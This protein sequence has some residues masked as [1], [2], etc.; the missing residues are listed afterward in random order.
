MSY[1]QQVSSDSSVLRIDRHEGVATLTLQR[2][3]K[4]NALNNEL[5]SNLVYAL[6]E[7]AGDAG[8]RALVI[9][10][11]GRGFCAGG[12]LGEAGPAKQWPLAAE[13]RHLR[14]HASV[15]DRMRAMPKVVVAAINGPCAG[16]GLSI[17]CAADLRYAARSAVFA[18]GFL[19]AGLPGDYG[20]SW[21]LSRLVGVG[22]AT[23]ILLTSPRLKAEEAERIGLVNRV[24]EDGDLL[25]EAQAV[26]ARCAAASPLAIRDMKRNLGDAQ[27]LPLSAY[28]DIESARQIE[29]S[30]TGDA[31]EAAAAFVE[32]RQPVFRGQ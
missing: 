1:Q 21:T 10:G 29:I 7:I 32:K 30:R 4:L 8:V 15:I 9:T 6:E 24:V 25:A 31:K 20:I 2:P 27:S 13:I 16:A 26:A 3:N 23:E 17:A 18:P 11:A 12:D 5:Q 22:R 14:F 28:L 19:N